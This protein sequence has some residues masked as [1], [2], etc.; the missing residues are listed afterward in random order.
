MAIIGFTLVHM[1]GSSLDSRITSESRSALRQ[2]SLS[3]QASYL[4]TLDAVIGMSECEEWLENN[5]IINTVIRRQ[6][7]F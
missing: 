4:L 3:H 1:F 6:C 7:L 5:P 2:H